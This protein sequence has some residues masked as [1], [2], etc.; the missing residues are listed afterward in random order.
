MG[1]PYH[2]RNHKS[3]GRS[4]SGDRN[5]V[6]VEYVAGIGVWLVNSHWEQG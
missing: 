1:Y 6:V 5:W 2:R 3:F 4:P